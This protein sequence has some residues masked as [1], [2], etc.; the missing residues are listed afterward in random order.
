MI[1][2]YIIFIL[3]FILGIIEVFNSNSLYIST[4][5]IH[6]VG[7]FTKLNIMKDKKIYQA[8]NKDKNITYFGSKINHSNNPNTY[9]KE[10]KS[11]W[12]VYAID[13]IKKFTELTLNYNDTPDFIMKPD[14]KW[15]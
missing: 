7:V 14:P 12:Y 15:K 4:S 11:G 9:L 5:L 8:I 1:I 10:T 6:G 2:K 3:I 13:Y